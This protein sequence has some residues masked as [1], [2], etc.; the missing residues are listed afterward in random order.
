[1]SSH[2]G[3]SPNKASGTSVVNAGAWPGNRAF[4]SCDANDSWP[5]PHAGGPP[6]RPC[7]L[8][9]SHVTVRGAFPE[10]PSPPSVHPE[11]PGPSFL[12]SPHCHPHLCESGGL[13]GS[14]WGGQQEALQLYKAGRH[15][16]TPTFLPRLERLNSRGPQHWAENQS[17]TGE[18]WAQGEVTCPLIS[19]IMWERTREVMRP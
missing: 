4:P 17:P 7:S 14:R 16:G 18:A 3:P 9:R 12:L 13:G 2:Q 5:W 19:Q 1:M 15:Q 10:R 6:G 11:A 8:G